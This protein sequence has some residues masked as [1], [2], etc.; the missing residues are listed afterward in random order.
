MEEIEDQKG[1]KSFHNYKPSI[2]HEF[3]F[4]SHLLLIILSSLAVENQNPLSKSY[5]QIASSSKSRPL[6]FF[7][8]DSIVLF[9]LSN[10]TSLKPLPSDTFF[11]CWSPRCVFVSSFN[12]RFRSRRWR[13]RRSIL[14]NPPSSMETRRL[15]LNFKIWCEIS[16]KSRRLEF[17]FRICR[18]FWGSSRVVRLKERLFW[19]FFFSCRNL[20]RRRENCRFWNRGRRFLKM[21]LGTNMILS[22]SSSFQLS[23]VVSDFFGTDF[24]DEGADIC[25]NCR[26]V[27]VI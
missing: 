11:S 26:T 24:W 3:E 16:W 13:E 5:L 14:E 6:G 23:N 27:I 2:I 1:E 17:F 21:K 19:D 7:E 22:T 4:R 20:S 8:I 12:H 9:T 18:V 10:P 25:R 15:R